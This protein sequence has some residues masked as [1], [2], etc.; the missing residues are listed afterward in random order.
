MIKATI[1]SSRFS[2]RSARAALSNVAA[3]RGGNMIRYFAGER[4]KRLIRSTPLCCY[5]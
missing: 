3:L 1:S 5:R 4:R 2:H